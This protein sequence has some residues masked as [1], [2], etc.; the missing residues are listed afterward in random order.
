MSVP[1][2]SPA[3]DNA[4]LQPADMDRLLSW[5]F[6][7]GYYRS[8]LQPDVGAVPSGVGMGWASKMQNPPH[9]RG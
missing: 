5:G 6:A 9:R 2:S 3:V 7:Q 1:F 8:G 4:S